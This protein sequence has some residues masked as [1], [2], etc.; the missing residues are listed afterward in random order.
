MEV[1]DPVCEIARLN[2]VFMVTTISGPANQDN[3][4]FRNKKRQE[5]HCAT[6]RM[7]SRAPINDGPGTSETGTNPADGLRNRRIRSGRGGG[8]AE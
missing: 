8:Q 6:V 4:A 7:N 1:L 5:K 3:V 2:R